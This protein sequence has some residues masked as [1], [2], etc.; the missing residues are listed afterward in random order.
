MK[1]WYGTMGLS[2]ENAYE[3]IK[4]AIDA[5]FEGIDSAWVYQNEDIIGDAVSKLADEGYKIKIQTKIWPAH[6]LQTREAFAGMLKRLKVDKVYCLMLHRPT[7]D[8]KE[9]L[10]AWKELIELQKEGKVDTIGVSNF[11]KDMIK[12][13]IRET[14]VKPSVNQVEM[15]VSNF[16]HDRLFYD[17]ENGI[18]TQAWSPMGQNVKANLDNQHI[19]SLALKYSCNPSTILLSFLTSQGIVPCSGSFNPI[20]IKQNVFFVQLSKEEIKELYELNIYDN[21]FEETYPE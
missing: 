11:D 3:C 14:G 1:T 6:Y 7:I 19:K 8:L 5:G 20:E 21:R 16:R 2:K 4:T 10:F 17:K 18:E 13:L 12:Y 9:T 15:S